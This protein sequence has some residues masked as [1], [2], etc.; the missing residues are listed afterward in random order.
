MD[1]SEEWIELVPMI[2]KACF[3]GFQGDWEELL[4]AGE[5]GLLKAEAGYDPA[6]GE[7]KPYAT[8]CIKNAIRDYLRSLKCLKRQPALPLTDGILAR[9]IACPMEI[10][11][12]LEAL[13]PDPAELEILLAKFGLGLT[14]QELAE[15][16]EVPLSTVYIQCGKALSEA[17]LRYLRDFSEIR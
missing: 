8:E 14:Y 6:I 13:V 17:R 11:E 12:L 1:L 9:D 16:R 7:F 5:D 4:R 2:A 15:E 10:R 3:A